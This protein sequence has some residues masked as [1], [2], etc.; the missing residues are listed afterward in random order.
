MRA[1]AVR[2]P[3]RRALTAALTLALASVA[4]TSA[5]TLQA[6][7]DPI[8]TGI[9]P[10]THLG[11]VAPGATIV[12]QV[13]FWLTCANSSHVN[14]DQVVT[15]TPTLSSAEEGNLSATATTIGPP[16]ADWPLDGDAC[17]AA[18]QPIASNGTSAV[19][20][21]APL[22][23]GDGYLFQ[24]GYGR[25]FEPVSAND[26][27]AIGNGPF[28]FVTFTLDVVSN[29]PPSLVLPDAVTLE[30]DRP[31]GA[32]AAF[33]VSATD[34][35]DDPDPTAVCMPAVGDFVPLGTTRVE[36]TVTD[37][38]GRTAAAGFDLTVVDTT[39]PSFADVP[40]GVEVTTASSLGA[41]V[42]YTAPT[43]TD[44][45]DEDVAI[46]CSPASG[47][48]F[49]IGTST[50]WCTAT[51]ASDNVAT[52][53]FPVTVRYVAARWESPIGGEPAWLVANHGRTIPVKLALLVSG[54]EL[55]T[56]SVSLVVASCAGGAPV[57]TVPMAW[58]PDARR[59]MGHLDTARLPGAGCYTGLASL[60]GG[61]GPSFRLDLRPPVESAAPGRAK[62]G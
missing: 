28:T 51:D 61:S 3:L 13:P 46:V 45:V 19:T 8:T 11:D 49:G 36:C 18:N 24:V 47:T 2:R 48:T 53:S 35:E 25:S 23:D 5:D 33:V 59:W 34:E 20:I 55:T 26:G 32:L 37:G 12:V 10:T 1:R 41:T 58:N 38:G 16:P 7:G 52:A 30:G 27:P 31:G 62:R 39:P 40:A 9:Q 43:A 42:T 60:D 21:V 50:V 6:D 4:F 29:T 22:I 44:L 17:S 15:I 14:R 57:A 56:G 54:A